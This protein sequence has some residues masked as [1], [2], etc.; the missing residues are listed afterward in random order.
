MLAVPEL[1]SSSILATI[2]VDAGVGVTAERFE[3]LVERG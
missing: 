2:A 1:V 3:E